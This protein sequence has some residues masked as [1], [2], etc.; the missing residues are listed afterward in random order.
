MSPGPSKCHQF[1]EDF[2]GGLVKGC[3]VAM[4]A[5]EN[6]MV[7]SEPTATIACTKACRSVSPHKHCFLQT[8]FL[9]TLKVLLSRAFGSLNSWMGFDL[10]RSNTSHSMPDKDRDN[11]SKYCNDNARETQRCGRQH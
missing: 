9:Q 2:W 6:G 3:C 5:A 7:I 1:L 11:G 8:L 10:V 4:V